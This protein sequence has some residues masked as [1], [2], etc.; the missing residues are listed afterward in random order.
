MWALIE[1][2]TGRLIGRAGLY[3]P[4]GWPGL[5]VGW[6][7][8]RDRWGQGFATEAGH[9]VLA[10]AFAQLSAD[11]LISLIHSANTASIRVAQRLGERLE[12]ELDLKGQRVPRLRHQPPALAAKPTRADTLALT[13]PRSPA[14][15]T[16]QQ[17][18]HP[19]RPSGRDSLIWVLA[20]IP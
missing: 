19:R 5:E 2:A 17:L 16:R 3:N 15:L 12:R 8:A 7:L 4:E 13:G 11:H 14:S 1:Q 20:H 18:G 6:L 9:T 10:Y